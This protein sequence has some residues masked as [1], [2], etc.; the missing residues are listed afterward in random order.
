L[1]DQERVALTAAFDDYSLYPDPGGRAQ[2][3]A[4]RLKGLL[5]RA[6]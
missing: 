6:K 5:E 2:H 4:M 1:T 3:I